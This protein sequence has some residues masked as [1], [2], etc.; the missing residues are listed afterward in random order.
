MPSWAFF[1]IIIGAFWCGIFKTS[2]RWFGLI[3]CLIGSAGIMTAP[4]PDILLTGDGKHLAIVEPG[5]NL[6]LLRPRAGEYVR[7]TLQE[8][9]GMVGDP[10]AIEDWAGANCSP[11]SCVIVLRRGGR[12]WTVLAIR[13]RYAI[14]AMELAA[15]CRR[16]D[17]V[18]SERWLPYSC[19]PHWIKA[20]R[21][22][23]EQTG[24]LAFY[25]EEGRVATVAEKS[26]NA[27]WYIAAQRAA[28]ARDKK[29]QVATPL[30]TPIT[31]SKPP[32]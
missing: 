16:A 18:I 23:W 17:I 14:P 30:A 5:Q 29:R 20:D 21:N 28:F 24:G 26:P 9:A 7:N 32:A 31:A 10:I 25:L 2:A 22:M 4:Y 12:D 15:A 27:P 19:K 8:N 13:T 3:P 1:I 6:V 11:D